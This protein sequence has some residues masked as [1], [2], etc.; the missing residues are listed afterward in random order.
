LSRLFIS[1]SSKDGASAIAF[2]QWLG[3]N[4]WPG[5]DVF[6]DLEDIGAG[7]VWKEALR[8]AHLRCEAVVLLASPDA[9]SSPECLTEV[10][11]AEDFGKEIIVVLLRDLTVDDRR[12][13]TYRERQIVDLSAPPLAHLEKVNFRGT[14]HD[15]RF[16][17]AALLKI[18]DYLFRRGI[19]PHSFPW[20]PEGRPDA[21]PFPGLGAFTEDD[22]GIF[23][24]RDADILNGLDEFRLLRR[25]GS[26]RFLAIQA[27][28]GAGKSSFLRAG[29]WPRLCR[30]SDFAP[31]AIV[32]PAQGILTGPEGLGRKLAPR[33]SRPDAP[34]NP[35]D[36]SARLMAQDAAKTVAEFAKIMAAA[37]AEAREQRRIVNPNAP[38]PAL[39]IA[40][41]QAEELLAP[42]DAEESQR[43]LALLA[44]LMREPPPGV[45]PFALL[46][47]R[48][49]SATRVCQAIVDQ[50]L[51]MP[52][53][54]TLL[55][56][57]Q[58]SYRDV[59][60]KPIEVMVRRGQRITI[61]PALADRLVGD[62][63]GADALPLLAFTLSYLYQGYAAGGSIALEQYAAVGG[64]AGVIDK[65]LKHALAKPGDTPAIPVAPEEQLACL[66]ATFI[67]WL[68][69]IEPGTNEPKRRVARL[70][71][72]LGHAP[73]MVDRLVKAR[74]LVADRRAGVDVVE[75]AHESLLRQWPALTAW[76]QAVA[77]DLR[78]V[79][80]VERAARE[81]V[82]NGRLAAW[83][84][85]R[86]DRL[87]AAERVATGEDFRRR[88]G[89]EGLAYLAA[90]RARETRQRRIAQTIAWSVAGVF[91]IFS[92]LL[93][94]EWRHTL[95]AQQET[96]ASLLI[97][98]S[99]LDLGNGNVE[100][101]VGEA[102]RAF[103]SVPSVASR[104][105]FV[106]A[107]MEVSPH[108]VAVIPLGIETGESLAWTSGSQLDFATASG[109]MRTFDLIAATKSAA[110]WDLPVIT[111]PQ[112]GNR[113]AVRALSPLG[114]ERMIAVFDE[115]SVG[116]YQ[117]GINEIRLQ[118]PQGEI[119]V[120]PIQH[121]VAIGHSGTLIALATTEATII[122]YRCDWTAP[123][124][125]GRACQPA[126]W[127]DVHGRAVAI[128]PDEKRIAV[129][130]RAGKVTIYNLSGNTIGA[131]KSFDAPINALGWAE[132]RDWLAVGTVKGRIAVLDAGT[133]QKT[134]IQEQT[135]G[136]KSIAALAWS[137]KEPSLA[138]VCNGTAVCLWQ[139]SAD[140]PSPNPFRPAMRFEGHRLGVTL[141]RF[142]PTGTQLASI[143]PHGT[144]RIWNLAQDGEVTYALYADNAAGISKVAVLP[145]GRFIAGGSTDGTIQIWDAQ[146]GASRRLVKPPEDFEVNDLAWNRN[147]AVASIDNNDTI[148]VITADASLPPISIP[149]KTRAGYHLAWADEDRMIAV[150]MSENGVILLDPQ[151]PA[152]EPLR[153]GV[154]DEQAWGV[155]AIP[156]SRLLLV[157]YVGGE[158][159]LWDLA[160]KQAVGSMRNPQ[161]RQGNRIGVGSLSVSSD[162]RLLAVSSGD[163]FVTV[164]DIARRAIWR[165][166]QTEADGIATV[167]FSPDGQKLAAFGNDK[168]L[169]IWTLGQDSAEFYLAAGIVPRRAI[170]GDAARRAEYAGWL[171]WVADDR[172]AVATGIAAI[173]VF[174][175]DAVKW[176]KRIDDLALVPE[177]PID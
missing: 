171:A 63:I 150:P 22:A 35:G 138:F 122:V 60:L 140:A 93:L 45:E 151:S 16:N 153:L 128:S 164:Y 2:K 156:G 7:E 132:Q 5:E 20:P 125:S 95:W 83:L 113:S 57:P 118:P 88:L 61:S 107:A 25:N 165:V 160:S 97:A 38:A 73:A 169:Y 78:I 123:S 155:A 134:I 9:L 173:S 74:L 167:A 98:R 92:V 137:P 162:G 49:D 80:S 58:T 82:R 139:A 106:Q 62:A 10:R 37:A 8:K 136:D 21:E 48:A 23:F 108:A 130:D 26:P 135:F 42:E 161:T 33:L 127:G 64:I 50:K 172:V 87:S 166:L 131:P 19:T 34:V 158:I 18:K 90:C 168:R 81:W 44:G 148:N 66:R 145:D 91:A 141:L 117:R 89:T 133:E 59:I 101:A 36:I 152:S 115:G 104:S 174:G 43:F 94:I 1:H 111:R 175:I 112:D 143:S 100:A 154:G 147:G 69:R 31:L 79:D 124:Q 39:V 149:I 51:E 55:P 3:A 105:A 27:A 144:L 86:T 85:H 12:L 65:A 103:R 28:S 47:V 177:T 67:P 159:K 72:F 119:S 121:A 129:G 126:P 109:R 114:T 157:S 53:T 116:V 142:S 102:E 17:N 99:E 32:R 120:N 46:T 52:K 30:D 70:D 11:K 75:V 170:V 163:R 56:L 41:D 68:A 96:E 15:V 14:Q 6:L 84:D 77:D 54:L 176:L 110:G 76:L 4:G 40:I 24:G 71:E 13:E 29:L 146:T